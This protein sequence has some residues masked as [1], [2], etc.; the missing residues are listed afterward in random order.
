[1]FLPIHWRGPWPK[2]SSKFAGEGLKDGDSGRKRDG[3]KILW[4]GPNTEGL[5]W[6]QRFTMEPFVFFV[7]F[8]LAAM[9]LLVL[10]TD[11]VTHPL[12]DM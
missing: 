4:L 9:L 1:M 5:W 12:R 8:E 2:C 11:G 6:R 10:L 7:D 3:L